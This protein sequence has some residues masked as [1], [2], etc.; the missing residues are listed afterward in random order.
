MNN[1]LS[2]QDQQA[3]RDILIEQ[4]NVAPSQLTPGS[5]IRADLGSDSL[6]DVEIGMSLED[7]FHISIPEESMAPDLTVG[8]LMQIVGEQLALRSNEPKRQE[9][10]HMAC[11]GM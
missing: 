8:D 5:K 6:D 4:L 2:E 7:R 3:V 10:T 1:F 11:D 9:P